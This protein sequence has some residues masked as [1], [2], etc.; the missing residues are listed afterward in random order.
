MKII[1]FGILL[2]IGRQVQGVVI[3]GAEKLVGRH[4]RH[5]LG[6]GKAAELS[7]VSS[8]SVVSATSVA[9]LDLSTVVGN[10]AGL[11]N[12]TATGTDST[13]STDSTL[14]V[15]TSSLT[16]PTGILTDSL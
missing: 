7:S 1:F 5:R 16:L 12:I 2:V 10:G 4:H 3:P 8:G 9:S 15:N 11:V 13:T 6:K 14:T